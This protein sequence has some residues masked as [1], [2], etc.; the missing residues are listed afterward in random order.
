MFTILRWSHGAWVEHSGAPSAIDLLKVGVTLGEMG[1]DW[2][3]RCDKCRAMS[4]F[5]GCRRC[6]I[7]L[8][9]IRGDKTE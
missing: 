2:T 8:A 5:Y 4:A 7:A 1:D 6:N 3:V 9:A